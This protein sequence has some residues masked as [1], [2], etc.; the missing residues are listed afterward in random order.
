MNLKLILL[1]FQIEHLRN[2]LYDLLSK[3][4][5]DDEKVLEYSVKLDKLLNE[6]LIASI[7]FKKAA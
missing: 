2:R 3:R 6:H 5:F 7:N 4:S 1:N